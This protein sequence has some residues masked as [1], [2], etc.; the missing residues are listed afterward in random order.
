MLISA[1]S[2]SNPG[3]HTYIYIPFLVLSSIMAY[4][5]RLDIVL[6][7]LSYKSG[8]QMSKVSLSGLNKV[9]MSGGLVLSGAPGGSV[10]CLFHL[11]EA[12][13]VPWLVVSFSILKAS[14]IAH[15]NLSLLP[16]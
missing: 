7:L 16:R 1:V 10:S 11:L 12:T 3:I 2:Q 14:N 4:P 9:K 8:S 13:F 6:N 15:S 5:K